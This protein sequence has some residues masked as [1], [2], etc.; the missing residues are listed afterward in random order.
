MNTTDNHTHTTSRPPSRAGRRRRATLAALTAV[1]GLSLAACGG[2]SGTATPTADNAAAATVADTSAST[3]ESAQPSG[4]TPAAGGQILP[5]ASDPISNTATEQTLTIDSVLVENN[6]DAAGK[7][8]DDHLEITLT[9]T[10]ATELGGFEIYSTF[11]DTTDGISESYYT[12]LPGTF[13]IPA[14]GTRVAHFDNTGEPDHFP[15]N[16]FSLYKTSANAQDVT[17][18]VS[19]NGAAVQT[20]TIMKDPGGAETAD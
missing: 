3:G 17:V 12:E 5:V 20:A 6:V 15:V 19:A 10:G 7:A 13:T 16:E 2:S 11:T 8:A 1:G 14:G 9:N 18:E 4:S